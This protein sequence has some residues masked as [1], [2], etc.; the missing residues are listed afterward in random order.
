MSLMLVPL[1]SLNRTQQSFL[2]VST[3]NLGE[4]P[5]WEVPINRGNCRL[6]LCHKLGE[7]GKDQVIPLSSDW[8]RKCLELTDSLAVARAIRNSVVK[9]KTRREAG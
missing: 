8:A 6:R 2:I 7:V 4:R 9:V 3:H 1:E 5:K